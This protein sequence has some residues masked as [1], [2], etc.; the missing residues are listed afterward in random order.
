MDLDDL[1][2]P[3]TTLRH[4]RTFT[5][6]EVEAF[7]DLSEDRGEHHE[8]PDEDGRLLV[9][10][11]LTATMPTKIGGDLDV[12]ARTMEFDFHRPVYT[13]QRIVCEVT[14]E[15]VGR[16]GDGSGDGT[17]NGGAADRAEIE[18]DI[19]CHRDGDEVVLTGGFEGVVLG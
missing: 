4:E 17:D 3:G 9:H 8:V 13:D 1:P 11:L 16:G 10:G 12:L 18:A 19:V 6:E 7:A 2:S 5:V 15:A 14:V